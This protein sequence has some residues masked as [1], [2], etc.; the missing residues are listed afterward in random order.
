MKSSGIKL[1]EVHGVCKS[2]DSNVQSENQVIEKEVAQIKPRLGQGR[3]GLRGIIKHLPNPIVQT[4]EK[5]LKITD[6]PK[7]LDKVMIMSNN[8]SY[9]IER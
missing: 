4:V 3:A 7:T 6:I 8:A 9:A 2:L 1:P 5:P